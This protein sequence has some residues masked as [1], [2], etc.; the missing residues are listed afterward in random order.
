MERRG[1][2]HRAWPEVLLIAIPIL[3]IVVAVLFWPLPGKGFW[4]TITSKPE[5]YF[6]GLVFCIEAHRDRNRRAQSDDVGIVVMAL[7]AVPAA[8]AVAISIATPTQQ[9]SV[10]PPSYVERL[11]E[12]LQNP[13]QFCSLPV[14]FLAAGWSWYCKWQLKTEEKAEAE[15]QKMHLERLRPRL[16]DVFKRDAAK[17]FYN[18]VAGTYNKRNDNTRGIRDAQNRIVEAV[19]QIV[20]GVRS[21]TLHVLDLGGGTGHNVYLSLRGEERLEWTSVDVS[22]EMTARFRENFAGTRALS[23]D[24]LELRQVLGAQQKF[25]VV[26]LSFALSSM[27]R[28]VDFGALAEVLS[29]RGVVLITDIHPGYVSKSPFFDIEVDG[30]SH[31]LQLRKVEPLLLE[32]EALPAG[33]SRTGWE[34]FRNERD[35]VYSYFVRFDRLP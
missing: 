5:W 32:S 25:D 29:S 35:E 34:I 21:G 4:S 15:Q 19:R 1:P 7:A 10:S 30:V 28:D 6:L 17:R 31:A 8:L 2:D 26:I 33:L 20:R 12:A 18:I 14:F 27:R 11:L 13:L 24:C 23:G 16:Y 3:V 22:E 9:L